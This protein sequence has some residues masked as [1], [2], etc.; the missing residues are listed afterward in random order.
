MTCFPVILML[1]AYLMCLFLS[2]CFCWCHKS[3]VFLQNCFLGV[4]TSHPFY[5]HLYS[6]MSSFILYFTLGQPVTLNVQHKDED[7]CPILQKS[8]IA[9]VALLIK[10]T[11]FHHKGQ[12][13]TK[14]WPAWHPCD[15]FQFELDTWFDSTAIGKHCRLHHVWMKGRTIVQ[16]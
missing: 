12:G 14:R 4:Q 7:K 10:R 6:V 2:L 13:D 3:I 1:W 16:Y 8:F 15:V 9:W 11:P 5:F